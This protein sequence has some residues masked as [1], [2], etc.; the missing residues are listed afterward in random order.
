[1]IHQSRKLVGDE[2][3]VLQM[4]LKAYILH[5]SSRTGIQANRH[6]KEPC[7]QY[8]F[9]PDPSLGIHHACKKV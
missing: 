9:H 7:H 8:N 1:M 2:E 6:T 3:V 5:L 4:N